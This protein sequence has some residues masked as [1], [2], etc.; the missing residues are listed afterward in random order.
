MIN[1]VFR[2]DLG[3]LLQKPSNDTESAFISQF[4]Q[5]ATESIKNSIGVSC[6][7]EDVVIMLKLFVKL[8]LT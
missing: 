4:N 5:Q 7:T 2:L 3:A 8:S 1:F 6:L